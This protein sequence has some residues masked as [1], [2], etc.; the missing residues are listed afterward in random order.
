MDGEASWVV[1]NVLLKK[2]AKPTH[3]LYM[4][5]YALFCHSVLSDDSEQ[6][7]TS[8]EQADKFPQGHSMWI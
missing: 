6:H 1:L 5:C 4:V 8:L 3:Q 2:I 7:Q